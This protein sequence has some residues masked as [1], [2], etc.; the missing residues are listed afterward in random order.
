MHNGPYVAIKLVHLGRADH[1][2]CCASNATV[3]GLPRS[4][5]REFALDILFNAVA[6]GPVDT[7]MPSPENMSLEG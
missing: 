2:G 3:I 6:P 4:W 7:P 1:S 5:V